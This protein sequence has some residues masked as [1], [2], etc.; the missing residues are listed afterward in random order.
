M[1]IRP[2]SQSGLALFKGYFFNEFILHTKQG[3]FL[4]LQTVQ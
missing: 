1:E 3:F 4:I 2:T